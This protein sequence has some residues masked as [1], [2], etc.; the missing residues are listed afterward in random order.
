LDKDGTLVRNVPYNVD[1]RQ[2]RLMPGAP[3][4]LRRLAGAGYRLIV[5]SNQSGVAFGMFAEHALVGVA[6]RLRQLFAAEGVTL[7]DFLWCPHH[8]LG[9]STRYAF[10]CDCRKPAPGLITRAAA[11]HA[12]DLGRS[13]LVGDILDDVEAG[14]RAGCRTILL[15]NGGETEWRMSPRRIADG[16]AG[17]LAEAA[18]MI[19]E[20]AHR[21]RKASS[22]Y[23]GAP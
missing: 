7:D 15:L 13:W 11:R 2:I 18:A 23:E 12:I 20:Q 10:D 6:D 21:E 5:V 17:D 3:A 14:R 4:A 19:L 9:V 16:S 1:P 8:P 22:Q